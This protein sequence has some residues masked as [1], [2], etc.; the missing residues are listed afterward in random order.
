MMGFHDG[1]I[2]KNFRARARVCGR[3]GVTW[4]SLARGTILYM[5]TYVYL[6]IYIYNMH[7]YIYIYI[8]KIAPLARDSHVT[9]AHARA[10]EKFL[11]SHHHGIPSSWNPT[12]MESHHHGIP[13]SWNPII[14]IIVFWRPKMTKIHLPMVYTSPGGVVAIILFPGLNSPIQVKIS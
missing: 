9:P 4:L 5:Y 13:S 3:A 7:M 1:G 6:Y 11:E 12:I 2:P 10:R 8:Y 14:I